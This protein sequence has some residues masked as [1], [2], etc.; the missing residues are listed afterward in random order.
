MRYTNDIIEY[1]VNL[2]KEHTMEESL[3]F[4]QEKYPSLEIT[5][6]KLKEMEDRYCIQFRKKG[7]GIFTDSEGKAIKNLSQTCGNIKQG[8]DI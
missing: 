8:D 5:E 1:V 7:F 6:E 3:K 2:G 4:I